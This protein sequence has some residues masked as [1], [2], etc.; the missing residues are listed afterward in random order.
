M[1][2]KNK[3]RGSVERIV[4]KLQVNQEHTQRNTTGPDRDTHQPSQ[5]T[6]STATELV[7][8]RQQALQL[9]TITIQFS[10]PTVNIMPVTITIESDNDYN[11]MPEDP[12]LEYNPAHQD[13]PSKESTKID[14]NEKNISIEHSLS[15]DD[16]S[17]NHEP[18]TDSPRS[19]Y[20]RGPSEKPQRL[21]QEQSPISSLDP[22]DIDQLN[23]VFD[24]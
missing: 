3:G 6:T 16:R 17:Q 18:L 5:A 7:R 19:N 10:P 8:A 20:S 21:A 11:Q 9:T 15:D 12:I 23:T 22:D 4:Q 2:A 14:N 1:N 13:L 24:N